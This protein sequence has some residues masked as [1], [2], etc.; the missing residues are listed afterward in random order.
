[1]LGVQRSE[2]AFDRIGG[3]PS[4]GEQRPSLANVGDLGDEG[5]R[6]PRLGRKARER[7]THL[8][9][10][11]S[12]T[13]QACRNRMIAPP[14]V[15]QAGR[16][17]ARE[18]C[19]VYKARRNQPAERLPLDGRRHTAL[20]QALA[21]LP[22]RERPLGQGAPGRRQTLRAPQFGAQEP[23]ARAVEREPRVK[24]AA[25]DDVVWNGSPRLPVQLERHPT[26]AGAAKSG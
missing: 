14:T 19:V 9:L 18:P 16:A 4:A 17:G 21:H 20:S 11:Q 2:R 10:F 12:V 22:A 25:H 15:G 7:G 24:A 6:T 1:M 3:E 13:L 23:Q 26:G 5:R 8:S